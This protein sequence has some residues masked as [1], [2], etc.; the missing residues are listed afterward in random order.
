MQSLGALEST[1]RVVCPVCLRINVCIHIWRSFFFWSAEQLSCGQIQISAWG[2]SDLKPW[3][4]DWSIFQAWMQATTRA[5]IG[6]GNWKGN[7]LDILPCVV[8]RAQRLKLGFRAWCNCFLSCH[9]R[10]CLGPTS[11]PSTWLKSMVEIQIL[12]WNCVWH[13]TCLS[14]PP[15]LHP[16]CNAGCWPNATAV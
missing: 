3:Q 16:T 7:I 14:P 9:P 12:I 13:S 1:S 11:R 4:I 15:I 2:F 5:E 10:T 6:T 8:W